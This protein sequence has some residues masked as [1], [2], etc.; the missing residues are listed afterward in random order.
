MKNLFKKFLV[1][2]IIATIFLLGMNEIEALEIKKMDKSFKIYQIKEKEQVV[3]ST[4]IFEIYHSAMLKDVFGEIE[5]EKIEDESKSEIETIEEIDLTLQESVVNFA[6]Q[7]VG[8]PYVMGGTS[9]TNGADCSGFVQ[10]VFAN[11]GISLPRTTYGQSV[12]GDSV[13][14][15]DIRIGDIISYGYDGYVTHSAIYVGNGTII[16]ASI[17]ELG[18]RTDTMYLTTPIV[19]IRRVM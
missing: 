14:I 18:I 6:L 15:E 8:N 16:H 1:L 17:P 10:S 19:A 12:S 2:S 11:F 5:E 9:L 13:D 7:F 3:E 4:N